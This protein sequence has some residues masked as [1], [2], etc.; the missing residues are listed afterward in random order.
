M[1]RLLALAVCCFGLLA[2][3]Q[4]AGLDPLED[5]L[6]RGE[7]TLSVKGPIYGQYLSN[8]LN[9]RGVPIGFIK[10]KAELR[11]DVVLRIEFLVNPLGEFT[12]LAVENFKAEQTLANEFWYRFREEQKL[13]KNR[14]RFDD[15]LVQVSETTQIRLDF[16]REAVY[17]NDDFPFG[18]LRMLPSGR[19]DRKGALQV[20]GAF[21]TQV[22]GQGEVKFVK[23]RQPP[24]KDYGALTK[25]SDIKQTLTLPMSF[26]FTIQHRKKPVQG[27]FSVEVPLENPL[28]REGVGYEEG[29][30]IYNPSFQA[31]GSYRLTP[32]FQ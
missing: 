31:T 30:Y 16:D 1:K 8:K 22:R 13:E 3:S 21:S 5:A 18:E 27:T 24:S 7:L 9:D 4:E 23:E 25:L 12:L 20:I 6:W 10:E 32:L 17:R 2:R 14:I 26:D 28:K 15:Q 19:M 29:N 11:L